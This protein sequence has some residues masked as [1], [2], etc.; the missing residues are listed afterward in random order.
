M[1]LEYLVFFSLL[2][3]VFVDIQATTVPCTRVI[4]NL[5]DL[6]PT[7]SNT[8]TIPTYSDC[9]SIV[10]LIDTIPLQFSTPAK[11]LGCINLTT[12]VTIP[13]VITCRTKDAPLYCDADY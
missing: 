8:T 3:S 10:L 4:T 13:I 9:S 6:Y 1:L 12:A 11:P 2:S 5:D 7:L